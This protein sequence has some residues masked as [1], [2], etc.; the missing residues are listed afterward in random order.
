MDIGTLVF[1]RL[2]PAA[3]FCCVAVSLVFWLF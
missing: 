2:L 1:D 3:V